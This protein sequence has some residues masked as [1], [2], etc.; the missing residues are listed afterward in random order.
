MEFLINGLCRKIGFHTVQNVT[1]FCDPDT[2]HVHFTLAVGLLVHLSVRPSLV[3]VSSVS[4][5][6]FLKMF[7]NFSLV[8]AVCLHLDFTAAILVV[9][10]QQQPQPQQQNNHNCSWVETK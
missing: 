5:M 3:S 4:W 6:K 10:A 2:D 7:K 8:N 1:P 9:T